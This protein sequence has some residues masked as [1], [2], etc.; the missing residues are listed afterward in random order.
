MAARE[1][2]VNDIK[3]RI[4][5]DIKLPSPKNEESLFVF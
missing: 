5:F 3:K 1:M 4:N 2:N